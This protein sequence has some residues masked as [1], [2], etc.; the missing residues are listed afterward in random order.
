MFL[1]ASLW[2]LTGLSSCR[3]TCSS[4]RLIVVVVLIVVITLLA[5]HVI[6]SSVFP[7]IRSVLSLPYLGGPPLQHCVFLYVQVSEK[8]ADFP[9]SASGLGLEHR[10]KTSSGAF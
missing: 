8:R 7:V 10:P 4:N 1:L 6:I 5:V 2:L 3:S 9:L